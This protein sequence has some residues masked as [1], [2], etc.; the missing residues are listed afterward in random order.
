MVLSAIVS[1]L[2]GFK[3]KAD[4]IFYHNFA[5]MVLPLLGGICNAAYKPDFN[6]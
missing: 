3:K 6:N 2:R 4:K 1:P 5:P